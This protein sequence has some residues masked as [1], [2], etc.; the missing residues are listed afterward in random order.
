MATLTKIPKGQVEEVLKALDDAGRI[1]SDAQGR[2]TL[3]QVDILRD[4]KNAPQRAS[5]SHRPTVVR[6]GEGELHWDHVLE[7]LDVPRTASDV[8]ERL[9]ANPRRVADML[10]R[11]AKAGDLEVVGKEGRQYLYSIREAGELNT[12][13]DV[14]HAL[15]HAQSIL[16]D[17][18][19]KISEVAK[20][21]DEARAKLT[22]ALRTLQ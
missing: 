7:A 13:Q 18:E 12:D 15:R 5:G 8:A 10:S 9:G 20:E 22:H 11:Y 4:L 21:R 6:S 16:K 17:V 14:I 19:G 3:T 1:Q 2:Y